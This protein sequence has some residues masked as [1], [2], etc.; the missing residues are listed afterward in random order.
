MSFRVTFQDSRAMPHPVHHAHTPVFFTAPLDVLLVEDLTG[1]TNSAADALAVGIAL[2]AIVA[3]DVAH[4]DD[5]AKRHFLFLF[6]AQ[7]RVS[8]KNLVK[9]RMKKNRGY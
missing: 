9:G 8:P 2:I 3:A 6:V 7:K 5:L 1:L 4:V